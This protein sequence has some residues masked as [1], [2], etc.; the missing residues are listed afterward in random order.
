MATAGHWSQHELHRDRPPPGYHLN[1]REDVS[2]SFVRTVQ[3]VHFR[4]AVKHI[5]RKMKNKAK[6]KVTAFLQR[7]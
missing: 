6:S 7:G 5:T 2:F 4:Q 1:N 3:R